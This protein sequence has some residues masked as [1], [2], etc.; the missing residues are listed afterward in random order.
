MKM[1]ATWDAEKSSSST[2]HRLCHI[3]IAQIVFDRPG[4][5]DGGFYVAVRMRN[6]ARR[7]LRSP[8]INFVPPRLPSTVGCQHETAAAASTAPVV[9]SFST[10]APSLGL[11]ALPTVPPTVRGSGGSIL[12]DLN[13]TIHYTH[14]LKVD[15]N[16]LQIVL[17]RRKKYRNTTMN[18]GYKTF[19]YC[20]ISLSQVLQRRIEHRFL[21]MY[22]EPKCLGAP[23][24]RIEVH[25]LSTLPIER[26]QINGGCKDPQVSFT[27]EE[28]EEEEEG[29]FILPDAFSDPDD[30]DHAEDS[31]GEQTGEEETGA[32]RQ[33]KIMKS[34]SVGQIKQ[35]VVRLLKRLKLF[36]PNEDIDACTNS[37]LWDDFDKME[38]ISDVDEESDPDGT[39]SISLHS[40]PR[41]NIRP[42]FGHTGSSEETL[43]VD[44]GA[45]ILRRLQKELLAADRSQL[46]DA[47]A[48]ASADTAVTAMTVIGGLPE[49]GGQASESMRRRR[50]PGV[51]FPGRFGQIKRRTTGRKSSRGTVDPTTT[52]TTAAGC[53][54]SPAVSLPPVREPTLGGHVESMAAAPRLVSSSAPA[55]ISRWSI[56]HP[57]NF[58]AELHSAD[59]D[60]SLLSGPLADVQFFV[61]NLEPGGRMAALALAQAHCVKL[62]C[63]SSYAEVKQAMGQ[64]AS[65]SHRHLDERTV[66]VCVVGGD[67]LLNSVLRAYVEQVGSKP[68]TVAAAFRF[69]MVPVSGLY[70]AF[71]VSTGGEVC[72]RSSSLTHQSRQTEAKVS[73]YN[74]GSPQL[75]S[76]HHEFEKLS[77]PAACTGRAPPTQNLVAQRLCCLDA[78]YSRLFADIASGFM[79]PSSLTASW[80]G[81]GGGGGGEQFSNRSS[82]PDSAPLSRGGG[83]DGAAEVAAAP[84]LR[85]RSDSRAPG[86]IEEFVHRLV[87]YLATANHL[88][89]LP[90]G[91]CLVAVASSAS[92]TAAAASTQQQPS[93]ATSAKAAGV[94]ANPRSPPPAMTATANSSPFA[95]LSS[96]PPDVTSPLPMVANSQD[97]NVLGEESGQVFVP[98]LLSVGLGSEAILPS[99]LRSS[100]NQLPPTGGDPPTNLTSDPPEQCSHPPG[101]PHLLSRPSVG[102]DRTT[103]ELQLEYWSSATTGSTSVSAASGAPS[104]PLS[105][106]FTQSVTSLNPGPMRPFTNKVSCRGMVVTLKSGGN[107]Q[108]NF[109]PSST[110]ALPKPFTNAALQLNLV[111]LTR[112][113]KPKIM[114]IGKRTK[115]VLFR[116][117][118]SEGLT[119]LICTCKAAPHLAGGSEGVAPVGARLGHSMSLLEPPGASG[120]S[121]GHPASVVGRSDSVNV[122][123]TGPGNVMVSKSHK[124]S[125]HAPVN[126]SKTD[127][128]SSMT[129]IF[130]ATQA[131]ENLVV[132]VCIDGVEWPTTK[133]FQ[134]SPCWRTHVRIFPLVTISPLDDC[135]SVANFALPVANLLSCAS[136]TTS[137]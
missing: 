52:T 39:E 103:Y 87:T 12:I 63:V 5:A 120:I 113:K 22:A 3:Q 72:R 46:P 35:K 122:P 73:A 28:E 50:T 56:T 83:S 110:I 25:C 85:R 16:I 57:S 51:K 88:L 75:T 36:D 129:S 44:A 1:S 89:P 104:L 38:A 126:V 123:S 79:T 2:I 137:P 49:R 124:S 80:G 55:P 92:T 105:G 69:Y 101:A 90:I 11:G 23:I 130:S 81:G 37:H 19:A 134:V 115:E 102:S 82:T 84:P 78:Y 99:C 121:P 108:P 41:P 62:A 45:R 18:L 116:P 117:E 32:N 135:L 53:G 48:N 96:S 42:F 71:S 76:H 14:V 131:S 66:R 15:S 86:L 98:F 91:E 6:N 61:S 54:G 74:T 114:R 68:E 26:D 13:C 29:D 118:V 17:Q 136:S 128:L 30:S 95:F 67:S 97:P 20:N 125:D 112:E 9:P 64:L 127:D 27:A 4:D 109:A 31:E 7:V 133:F 111:L 132:R 77:G 60:L 94:S 58:A 93:S 33:K 43:S 21:D 40:T 70:A 24:G 106:G 59:S 8:E 47:A 34:V 107:S 65:L 10:A 119:R 100:A